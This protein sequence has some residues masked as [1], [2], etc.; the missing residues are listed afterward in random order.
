MHFTVS[1]KLTQWIICA[2]NYPHSLHGNHDLKHLDASRILLFKRFRFGTIIIST[3]LKMRSSICTADF[4]QNG[5]WIHRYIIP[6][7]PYPLMGP[8]RDFLPCLNLRAR[9]GAALP[10]TSLPCPRAGWFPTLQ[11]I[12]PALNPFLLS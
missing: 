10:G 5:P 9:I 7:L 12:I 6:S 11:S 3:L 4:S 8:G 1:I 2:Q